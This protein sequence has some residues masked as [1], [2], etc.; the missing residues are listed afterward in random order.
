MNTSRNTG[1]VTGWA[2][3]GYL[4]TVAITK[5][6]T[7]LLMSYPIMWLVRKIFGAA[8]LR[9]AFGTDLSYW[10]CVGLFLIW[11]LARVKIKFS[12]EALIEIQG[13]R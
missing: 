9:F 13:D 2:A 11:F 5:V 4:V 8:L 12:D 3:V 1:Q 7:A 6:L 10:R